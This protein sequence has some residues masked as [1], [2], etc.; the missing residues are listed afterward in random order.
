MRKSYAAFLGVMRVKNIGN[1]SSVHGLRTRYKW[2]QTA[3]SVV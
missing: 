1:N 3:Q 2:S